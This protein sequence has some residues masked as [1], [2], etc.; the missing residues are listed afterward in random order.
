MLKEINTVEDAVAFYAEELGGTPDELIFQLASCFEE[1]PQYHLGD[2]RAINFAKFL[3]R[4]KFDVS[5]VTI[6]K[7]KDALY[8]DSSIGGD[9]ISISTLEACIREHSEM[10]LAYCDVLGL[11]KEFQPIYENPADQGWSVYNFD[12]LDFSEPE[13]Q[14]AFRRYCRFFKKPAAFWFPVDNVDWRSLS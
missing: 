10:W 6:E 14:D 4:I 11:G 13:L 9:L 2:A 12:D 5:N 8:G 1:C 3:K 7:F